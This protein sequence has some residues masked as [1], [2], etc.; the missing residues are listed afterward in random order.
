MYPFLGVPNTNPNI[1]NTFTKQFIHQFCHF[2]KDYCAHIKTV[3]I[4]VK[5]SCSMLKLF[6]IN[7]VLFSLEPIL[8]QWHNR[9]TKQF[10]NSKKVKIYCTK[11]FLWTISHFHGMNFVGMLF[12][13][14]LI[15]T[16]YRF[17]QSWSE[18]WIR[19]F[20]QWYLFINKTRTLRSD[21]SD[22]KCCIV[23][24]CSMHAF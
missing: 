11:S 2:G 7:I 9:K 15:Y 4:Y 12:I 23:C 3:N 24:V 1:S 14:C 19:Y 8:S 18:P 6:N 20:M 17:N 21:I 10:V 22:S 5:R 16:V 13:V